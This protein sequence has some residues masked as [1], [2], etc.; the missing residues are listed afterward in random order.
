M[1]S[2]SDMRD[3]FPLITKVDQ[4]EVLLRE[5]DRCSPER[6]KAIEMSTTCATPFHEMADFISNFL[7]NIE[8]LETS[9][10]VPVSRRLFCLR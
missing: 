10:P 1:A 5:A 3:A 4:T 6:L 8:D 7:K 9:M 2:D